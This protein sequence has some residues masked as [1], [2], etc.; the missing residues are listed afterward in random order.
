MHTVERFGDVLATCCIDTYD[1]PDL[2]VCLRHYRWTVASTV[3]RELAANRGVMFYL[4][5]KLRMSRFDV[6]G[7][8]HTATPTLCSDIATVLIVDDIEAAMDAAIACQARRLDAYIAE[9]SGWTLDAVVN[10]T[11]YMAASQPLHGATYLPTP[12]RCA[13]AGRECRACYR[14]MPDRFFAAGIN[15]CNACTRKWMHTVER[16]GDGLATCCIDTYDAPNLEVCLRHYRWTVTSTV[17]STVTRELAANRGVK[18]YLSVNLR[19][20]RFDVDGTV[21]TATTTLRSDIATVLIVDDIEAAMDAAIACLARRLDAYIAEASGWTLDAVVNITVYMAASQPLHG[22]TYL[23]TPNRCAAAGRECRACYRP[24]PDRFFAAGINTCNACT[25]KWMHTVERFGD[26]LATCCIDT[27]DAPD[28]EACLCHYRWTVASTVTRKL[29]ANRGVKF[30]LSVN[31][32]MSRFDVDG[33]VHT[34]TTTLRSDIATVLIVDDIEAAMDAAIACLARRLDA[35]IAEG[36]G[37]TLD[38][39]VNI[40]VYMAAPQPLH[41]AT[42]LPTP[43]RCAAAGRECRACYRPMPDRF[44]AAGINTCNACTRKWMHTVERFGDVLATCCIDTYD[45]PNLEVCLRHYRWTVASTVTRELA[46][47]RGVKFYLSAKLRMSRFDV[48]GTVHT[49]TPTLLRHRHRPARRRHRGGYGR[50]HR[51]PSTTLR[52]LH[53]GGVWV[54]ARRCREHYR[55]HSSVPAPA[56]SDLP[57]DPQPLRCGRSRVSGMIPSHA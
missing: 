9:G 21:H 39:V 53:C 28:L 17:A 42:Y 36:S 5:A 30:Y 29:A 46:A 10:I 32:R 55:L 37:W 26:V 14:P 45:A 40:T 20:S 16:F 52:R 15:T 18:F 48:D 24:M 50:G 51:V 35:Y 34:A 1:A 3:T 12:N 8:V 41:G 27:Y 13:A 6:D 22:A 49:A 47:N 33:T 44:F 11:V 38:A 19:M 54:D 23:P 56:R 31:L 2:E 43:N 7:T 25:R 4:S 57:P